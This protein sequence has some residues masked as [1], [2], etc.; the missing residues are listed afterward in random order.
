[1]ERIEIIRGPGSPLY[2]TNALTSVIS[3]TTRGIP[4]TPTAAAH[5]SL[6][7]AG[8]T[9]FSARAGMRA[10]DWGFSLSGGLN[11]SSKLAD[12][13]SSALDLKRFRGVL[14]HR[15]N[16]TDRLVLDIGMSHCIGYTGTTMGLLDVDYIYRSAHLSYHTD[17]LRA[18]LWW[19][20]GNIAPVLRFPLEFAGMFIGDFVPSEVNGH[21]LNADLQWT[22]PRIW[23]PLLLIAGAEGRVGFVNSDELLSTGFADIESPRYH[24]PGISY[25]EYQVGAYIHG[26]WTAADWLTVTAGTHFYRNDISGNFLSPRLTTVFRLAQN[27][28]LRVGAARAFRKPSF[29]E[30]GL[31]PNLSYPQD[32]M[33]SAS[34]QLALQEFMTRVLGGTDLDNEDLLSMEVGYVGRFFE[35]RLAA[36]L[37]LYYSHYTN[38][39]EI[40]PNMVFTGTGLPDF[41]LSSN[42]FVNLKDA[43]DI[44]GAE[45]SLRYNPAES[46]SLL[47]TWAYREVFNH[48]TGKALDDSPKNYLTLGG[49]YRAS[50]G[51]VMSLY[52]F[53]RSG[54]VDPRM[55]NPEN[56]FAS[57]RTRQV[58]A[59]MLTLSR[60][61]WNWKMSPGGPS[62]EGGIKLFLPITPSAKN[63]FRGREKGGGISVTGKSY[64][65]D[66][67][68]RGVFFYIE[69]TAF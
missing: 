2:G 59:T 9:E 25:F 21:T 42:S 43:K 22:L 37:D 52:A 65:V 17:A 31:H 10:G 26:E 61:G 11:L 54:F 15:L 40:T 1:V 33:L 63:K 12:T 23:D 68:A 62:L 51:L 34:D 64:G 32:S 41:D 30:I 46:L 69:G 55:E 29:L 6:G 27:Q 4:D 60:L 18:Q 20:Q 8:H 66:E 13:R 16:H 56:A 7:E 3:I 24:K 5:L 28:T 67:L 36:S 19:T 57:L 48:D 58:P 47:A 39:I 45:L 50:V 49:R 14:E 38:I 44:V 35:D 53:I